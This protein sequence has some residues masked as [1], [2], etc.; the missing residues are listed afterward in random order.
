MGSAAEKERAEQ[1]AVASDPVHADPVAV[2]VP[3]DS[4][5]ADPDN[6]K[7][8]KGTRHDAHGRQLYPWEVNPKD[9]VGQAGVEN[10]KR[11]S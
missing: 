4:P 6:A 1:A 2:G 10:R 8:V 9:H 11:S 3:I 7:A 5:Q